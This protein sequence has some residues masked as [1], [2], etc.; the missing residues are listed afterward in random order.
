MFFSEAFN[1][2]ARNGHGG[3]A[4]LLL[5]AGADKDSM[6]WQR[7]TALIWASGNGHVDVVTRFPRV[8]PPL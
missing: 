2:Q 5:E 8:P 6:D 3:V 7:K 1:G 4:R